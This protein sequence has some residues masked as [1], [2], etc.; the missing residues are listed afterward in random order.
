MS[1]VFILTLLWLSCLN[2]AD[3]SFEKVKPDV[4]NDSDLSPGRVE[5]SYYLHIQ[6][7]MASNQFAVWIEDLGGNYIATVFVT[8]YTAHGGYQHRPLS[9]PEWRRTSNWEEA[10]TDYV[11][12][13]SG[14]TP[15][16]GWHTIIWDCRDEHGFSVAPGRYIYR[17]EGNIFWE[18]MVIWSGEIQIGDSPDQSRA[19]ARYIPERAHRK[20][21]L[22]EEVVAEFIPWQF[23]FPAK[24]K[25]E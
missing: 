17:I 5:I 19:E 15:V 23:H 8:H 11:D 24:P 25:P 14:A 1:C 2:A 20:G 18:N 13:V 7:R 12:A 22:L 16:S 21:I 3:G 6:P 10:G 9:L 4:Q